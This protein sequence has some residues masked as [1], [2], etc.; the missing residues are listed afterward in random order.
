MSKANI[1]IDT[2]GSRIEWRNA[3]RRWGIRMLRVDRNHTPGG[4]GGGKQEQ[5]RN[6]NGPWT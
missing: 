5:P 6:P 1:G 2:L 3:D 4:I